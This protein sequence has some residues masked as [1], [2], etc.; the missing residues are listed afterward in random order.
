[1]TRNYIT[2]NSNERWVTEE[3]GTAPPFTGQGLVA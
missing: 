2:L 3:K 1:M